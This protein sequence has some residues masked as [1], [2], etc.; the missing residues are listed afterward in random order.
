[1]AVAERE[2][3]QLSVDQHAWHL[4]RDAD[5][6]SYPSDDGV[7]E[8]GWWQLLAPLPSLPRHRCKTVVSSWERRRAQNWLRKP[9]IDYITCESGGMRNWNRAWVKEN[10]VP[11]AAH[12]KLH[13]AREAGG[14]GE[15]GQSTAY[16]Q[17]PRCSTG[18]GRRLLRLKNHEHRWQNE[19]STRRQR[20]RY[21]G[22]FKKKVSWIT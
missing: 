7:G 10:C 9:G 6:L 14:V 12:G 15:A 11:Y 17:T 16:S 13:S 3:R 4:E 8:G 5:E 20:E 21:F 18:E 2:C 1:M 22:S 19:V